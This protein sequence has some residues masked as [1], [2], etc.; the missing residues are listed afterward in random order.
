ML[1]DKIEKANDIKIKYEI[2]NRRSG[3][4]AVCFADPTKA[5]EEL[6]WE[7]TR[8]LEQMCKDSWKYTKNNIK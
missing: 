5:K 6:G 8:D 3:D 7:A 1:L 2:T 4:I